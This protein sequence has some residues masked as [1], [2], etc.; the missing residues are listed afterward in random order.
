MHYVHSSITRS[1]LLKRISDSYA[2][3]KNTHNNKEKSH[4]LD[5]H[6]PKYYP[7]KFYLKVK[8]KVL[9]GYIPN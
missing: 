6:R 8:V 9:L 3:P 7:L 1:N 4:Y 2:T 5:I